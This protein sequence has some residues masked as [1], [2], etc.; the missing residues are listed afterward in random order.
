VLCLR[1]VHALS[2]DVTRGPWLV[3]VA[4]C[5]AQTLNILRTEE[6][7]V[8]VVKIAD[9]GVGRVMSAHT[10]MLQV[11]CILSVLL[12]LLIVCVCLFSRFVVFPF[13]TPT[14]AAMARLLAQTFY[15]TPLYASPELCDNLPYNEKTDIW[16]LGVVL[17]ELAALTPPFN[18]TEHPPPMLEPCCVLNY[19]ACCNLVESVLACEACSTP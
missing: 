13:S 15:G 7:G 14:S 5:V 2:R 11:R 19:T 10:V 12:L 9:L 6:D 8:V 1:A 17:Y 16:S 3:L 4:V 18:G